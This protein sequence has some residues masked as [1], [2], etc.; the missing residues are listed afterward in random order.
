MT[1]PGAELPTAGVWNLGENK[2]LL[3]A[4]ISVMTGDEVK[5]IGADKINERG[6]MFGYALGSLKEVSL[7]KGGEVSKVWVINVSSPSLSALRKSYGL[8]ALLNDDHPFHITIAVR[9]K[10]VLLD[11]GKAKGYET[12][13][14]SDESHR[15]SA[16]ISR[17]ELKA[18]SAEVPQPRVRI[19]LPYKGKY[20]LE[21]LTNPKW[22]EN[23]GKRRFIGGGIEEGETPEQAAARELFEELSVKIKPTAFRAIGPDNREGQGHVQYLELL[24]HRLKPGV[25]KANVGSDPYITLDHGMPEGPDY[26]GPDIKTLLAPALKKVDSPLKAA[27]AAEKQHSNVL[28]RSGKKDLLPGGEADNCPD[29]EF[30]P[31]ALAEGAEHEHEHTR[32]NQIAKEIAKD[33]LSEDPAYYEKIREVEKE[34]ENQPATRKPRPLDELLAA[35][36]H[37]DRREYERKHEILRRLIAKAPQDWSVDD[38][39]PKYKGITHVPTQ[40]RFHA[41]SSVIG[42]QVKAATGSVYAQ[43]F[44]NLLDFRTPIVFDH[45]KPVF[46]NVVDHLLQAKQK[47]DF[48]LGSRMKAHEY[49]SMLDPQYRYQ[50]AQAAATGTLPQMNMFDKATQLYGNDVFDTIKNWGKSNVAS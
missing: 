36:A 9:R 24:K 49:R 15:F 35:K 16:P 21:K 50:M 2:E 33:H 43:Q 41:P 8:S 12:P 13:T 19:V 42:A 45:N 48:I 20:L 17:G 46:A 31:K 38:P 25:F 40:F 1:E 29:R 30:S 37:S 39:K 22:P 27:S 28:S 23:L 18:A 47:G 11:N 26:H 6:H 3:N 5:K 44:R 7:T 10:G 4:H 32:N 14:E 34:A